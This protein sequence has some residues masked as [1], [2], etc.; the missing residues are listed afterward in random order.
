MKNIF[1]ILILT[2]VVATACQSNRRTNN[3]ETVAMP[4]MDIAPKVA[5]VNSPALPV[6]PSVLPTQPVASPQ[7]AAG[8]RPAVNPAH[9][10]PFH[11]CN[12]AVGAALPPLPGQPAQRV[13][14]VQSVL[15]TP[16]QAI[17]SIQN[18]VPAKPGVKLNPAHGQPGH[19]CEIAVGA[20]LS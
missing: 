12:V 3:K 17:P 2:I 6:N 15:S 7:G 16:T 19:K 13:Q 4:V 11:D 1:S 20:P 9:G 18:A 10:Q 5:P 14:P 8:A